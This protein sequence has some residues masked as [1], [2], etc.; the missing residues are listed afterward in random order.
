MSAP[1]FLVSKCISLSLSSLSASV[2]LS[3]TPISQLHAC[4]CLSEEVSMQELECQ[5]GSLDFT[6]KAASL[7]KL[8]QSSSRGLASQICT[9]EE[10]G[11][12]EGGW[13]SDQAKEGDGMGRG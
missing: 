4:L 3:P 1:L 8:R 11:V 6:L 12:L 2:S 7:E 13:S 9:S 5:T 10:S